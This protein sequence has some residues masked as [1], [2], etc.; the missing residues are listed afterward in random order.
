MRRVRRVTI[1]WMR[2]K[3]KKESNMQ[4]FQVQLNCHK[5]LGNWHMFETGCAQSVMTGRAIT[6]CLP[7]RRKL[8]EQ[9]HAF[10]NSASLSSV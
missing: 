9:E 7:I 6:Q 2:I 5:R 1:L 8:C 10:M 4:A 3:R